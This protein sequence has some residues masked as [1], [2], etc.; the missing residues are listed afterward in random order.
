MKTPRQALQTISVLVAALLGLTVAVLA[1]AAAPADAAPKDIEGFIGGPNVGER[2]GGLFEQPGDVAVYTGG[3]ADTS[4][5]KIFV[6]EIGDGN[7]RVQRLDVHGNFELMWGRDV[8]APEAPGDTGTGAEICTAALSGAENCQRAPAGSDEGE[9][10]SP[11]GIAVDQGT[12]HVFVID[13]DN[14]RV[15]EFDIDGNFVRAWGEPGSGNG[16]FGDDF[17][18]GQGTGIAVDPVNGD[19]FV[20]DPANAR[21]QQFSSTGTFISAFGTAG[22]GVGELGFG[23]PLRLAV[24][25]N[26]IVYI[27][28]SN[29]QSDF[30]D[31]SHVQRYDAQGDAFLAPIACCDAPGAPLVAGRTIGLEIDPDT[32]GGG[33]DEE[34]LLVARDP[35]EGDTVVQELD[36]PTPPTDPVVT[37]VDTHVYDVD[38]SVPNP[39]NDRA[40]NGIGV[41]PVNGYVYLA[42]QGITTASSSNGTFTGCSN[43]D[44][45]IGLIVLAA[46]SDPVDATL[47]SADATATTMSVTGLANAGDGV[48][49]YRFEILTDGQPWRDAGAGGYV[50]GPDDELVSGEL[51]GLQPNTPY[52]VRLVVT[53]QASFTTPVGDVS[54][55]LIV[56]T[57]AARP[58][59]ETL[60][61][62]R[63]TDTS[64]RLRAL[65]DPNGAETTYR[66]EYG[67]VGGP[68]D[69]AVPVPDGSAG[70]GNS[71]RLLVADVGGLQPGTAYRY[72]IVATNLA[73]T[74]AGEVVTFTTESPRPPAAPIGRGYEL[75]SPADKVGGVGVGQ[76]YYG[77]AAVASVGVAAYDKDRFALSGVLGSVLVDGPYTY[78]N[79]WA[80][81]E[82]AADG[83]VSRPGISRR[84][85]G[86]QAKAD[87]T[88]KA[89]AT[90]LSLSV[91]GS[92]AH[93]L[94]LFPE[95]ESF[96][97]N[98]VM[99]HFTS[100]SWAEL[101]PL[102][103]DQGPALNSRPAVSADGSAVVIWA[104]GGEP[105]R[106]LGGDADP[107]NPELPDL[108]AGGSVYLA[109]TS[110]AFTDV[111][112]GDHGVRELVNACTAGTTIP[113][114]DEVTPGVF[115]QG[116]QA[117]PPLEGDASARLIS[118]R[119]AAFDS[120]ARGAVSAD[121]SRVFFMSPDPAE[122]VSPCDGTGTDSTCPAQLYVRQRGPGG[123]VTRWIS[124]TEVTP[125]NGAPSRQ[126]ASLM[127]PAIFLGA[128]A[129]GDKAFF[130]T[131][132]PLTS[133]DPNGSSGGPPPGGVTTGQPDPESWD[134]YM[135]D[136]PDGPDGDPATPDGDPAGGNLVR[137]SAGPNGEGDCNV[138]AGGLRF[139]SDDGSRAYFTCAAPLPGMPQAG[140]G[141]IAGPGGSQGSE[142]AAN[143]YLHDVADP[144]SAQWR[145]IARLPR[146]SELGPC[147]TTATA[148][149][150]T[151]AANLGGPVEISAVASCVRG[152]FDGSLVTFFTAGRLTEDDPDEVTGDVY[153]YDAL[154]DELT[155]LSA[156]QAGLDD[157]PYMCAPESD[158]VECHGDGGIGLPF[159]ALA[160]LG[161]A[162]EP[163]GSRLA[164]F[165]SRS[166][167]VPEDTDGAYD[168]YQWRRG[169]L[170]LISTGSS[171]TDGAFFVGN[172]R[173]GRNVYLATRDRLTWQDKDSVLDVYTAR[174]GG[175]IPEP[176][177][178][179][180][181]D[182]PGGA[183]QAPGATPGAPRVDSD[184]PGGGN[185]TQ[186]GRTKLAFLP[187]SRRARLR[188]ARTGRLAVRLKV[189]KPARMTVAARGAF[190]G[191]SRQVAR[192][193]RRVRRAGRV[194][195]RMRLS[196]S[197]RLRLGSGK[198]LRLRLGARASGGGSDSMRVTLRDRSGR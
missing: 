12:G 72:R 132:S 3:T 171:T 113:A 21:V 55:E 59:V 140:S 83:W 183:C 57:D 6:V 34:H 100:D 62:S 98:L 122:G 49:S 174:L 178:P 197:A 79:D 115:K 35:N 185:A 125:P 159:M 70:S 161:V 95:L 56:V 86:S 142:D 151:L 135:Y 102:E 123:V 66:F 160:R 33:P 170:S 165:Q 80:F 1:M 45:C 96:P 195:V 124:Q 179:A 147:A 71:P 17:E 74:S 116:A 87:I 120:D 175:G 112:P 127:S 128:S 76:W 82:R 46:N 32:D 23:E 152:T 104:P 193:S 188:A 8:I 126:D 22:T 28:D 156:P 190:A 148:R 90:D 155:R 154:A 103:A 118:P 93:T 141:T 39:E 40:V 173:S 88:M 117:C 157:D 43:G 29:P 26:H 97:S 25:S 19:V 139:V 164:F 60:G 145:F 30:G 16:Q 58:D 158:T 181:C 27:S 5:D 162:I 134:L 138:P 89:A 163:G 44:S 168:V 7:A 20:A 50:S 109:E 110:G 11:Y 47:L 107:T 61:S 67:P 106:G 105:L 143:L 167:L 166:R 68:F 169:E 94:K 149:G 64:A 52:R 130:R 196:R 15:Q 69:S 121:G 37:V 136:L 78:S 144:A 36:I 9:F 187:M 41:N 24:D 18:G 180:R 129:D 92:G 84:A 2:T 182:A 99:R 198:A 189:S 10:D 108:Q 14:F 131:A 111:F 186:R 4:D 101:A 51:T 85:H 153:G 191:K 114:R 91:W 81:A 184:A 119:G 146:S 150:S 192:K 54:N 42:V 48:A 31:Q 63:R 77:P 137:I 177:P 53:K 73:G 194:V 172:D 176:Q 65:V 75:V 38:P 13:Q 133:D